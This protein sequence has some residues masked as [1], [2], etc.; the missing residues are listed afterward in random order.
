MIDAAV[1]A[2]PEAAYGY[3][4]LFSAP[5]GSRT[6]GGGVGDSTPAMAARQEGGNHPCRGPGWAGEPMVQGRRTGQFPSRQDKAMSGQL[7]YEAMRA[8]T[9]QPATAAGRGRLRGAWH[10]IRLA[11]QEMNYASG[12]VVE[13]QAPWSVDKQ[14]HSR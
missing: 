5:C 6:P 11:I 10:R 9:A 12:R 4:E 3:A 13:L 1:R 2:K 8:R 7:T 14:W